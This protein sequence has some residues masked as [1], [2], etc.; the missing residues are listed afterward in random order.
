MSR[1]Y[2]AYLDITGRRCVVIGAGPIAERKVEQ[3]LA[4]GADVTVVS[5]EAT[6]AIEQAVA[7]G[8]VRLHRRPYAPGDLAQAFA[9]FV[10]TDDMSVS[11]QVRGEATR[12]RVLLNVADVPE[13]CDFIA[14]AVV[15]R[16]PV[17][18]AVSTSG[19]S[20]ALA[21]KLREALERWPELAW[22][23]AAPLLSEVRSELKA[24][25]AQPPPDAWQQA[26]DDALLALVLSGRT[27][28]AKARL[29]RALREASA[30]EVGG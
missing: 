30:L 13:L 25:G 22:A 24:A 7:D 1:Y 3:L 21:R 14:P 19:T 5:P 2:A 23:D 10:A 6:A 29:L 26:M 11:R 8:R 15:E 4:A 27:A 28:E 20:P 18:V 9:A 16:G 12:E 17:M